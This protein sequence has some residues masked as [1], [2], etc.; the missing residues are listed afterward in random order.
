VI[1]G[2]DNGLISG[3]HLLS[4]WWV[5]SD[6]ENIRLIHLWGQGNKKKE[7]KTGDALKS[8]FGIFTDY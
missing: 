8:S 6:Q 1:E 4:A 3:Y 7:E 2:T 5:F